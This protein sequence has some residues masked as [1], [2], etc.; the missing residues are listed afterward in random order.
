MYLLG[1]VAQLGERGLC[2]PEVVG[3]NPIVSTT[4]TSQGWSLAFLLAVYLV[5]SQGHFKEKNKR[6]GICLMG[7]L[8]F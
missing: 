5:L 2:K 8:I 7:E 1:D 6:E 4:H 3:S